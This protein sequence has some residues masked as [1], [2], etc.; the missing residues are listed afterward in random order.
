MATYTNQRRGGIITLTIDGVQYDAKGNFSYDLGQPKRDAIIG[1]DKVHGFK[2][3]PKAPYI[4]GEI[5]DRANMD[6]AALCALV[7]GTI[8]LD[9]ANG[10]EIVLRQA[11]FSGD[12]TVQTQEANIA[13]Q[14]QGASAEEISAS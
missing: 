1:A 7:E 5:T 14:F 8:T 9:L 6:V 10:K 3:T 11:W 13:V 4:E 2:E 12:G